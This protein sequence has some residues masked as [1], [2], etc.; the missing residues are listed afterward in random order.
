VPI[1]HDDL[2]LSWLLSLPL[3]SLVPREEREHASSVTPFVM[4]S[5]RRARKEKCGLPRLARQGRSLARNGKRLAAQP[6]R[7]GRKGFR[8]GGKARRLGREGFWLARKARRVAR[9][10]R[11]LAD[12]GK[13]LARKGLRLAR[14]CL[15]YHLFR[16]LAENGVFY[17][18]RGAA[19]VRGLLFTGETGFHLGAQFIQ[20]SLA[21]SL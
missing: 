3:S 6:R 5:P 10:A 2:F 13:T 7:L 14:K 16:H 9:K 15:T 20:I 21:A 12:K 1:K 17:S 19:A 11:R 4:S 8:L 18:G